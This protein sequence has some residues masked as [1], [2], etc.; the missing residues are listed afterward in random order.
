MLCGALGCFLGKVGDGFNRERAAMG[1]VPAM[2]MSPQQFAGIAHRRAAGLQVSPECVAQPLC[3]L[4]SRVMRSVFVPVKCHGLKPL[5][6]AA[7]LVA[8]RGRIAVHKLSRLAHAA[9][10]GDKIES[11]QPLQKSP[12]SPSIMGVG[13]PVFDEMQQ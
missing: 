3:Q 6:Q 8:D 13:S 12:F 10:S 9:C 11:A 1:N 4:A 5:F 2:R 7:Q